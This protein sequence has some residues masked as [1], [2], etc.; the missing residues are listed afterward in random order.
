M[1]GRRKAQEGKIYV[2]IQLICTV[3]QQ[4]LT[5]HCKA[6]I[7]HSKIKPKKKRSGPSVTLIYIT[8]KNVPF[9]S[10]NYS[11]LLCLSFSILLV[12]VPPRCEEED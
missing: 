4:K 12:L 8:G 3:V 9:L 5:Q 6:S 7:L 1:G 2:E 10:M 11:S